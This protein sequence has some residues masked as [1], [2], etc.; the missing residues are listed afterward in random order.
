MTGIISLIAILFGT[1]LYFYI[2]PSKKFLSLF[3]HPGREVSRLLLPFFLRKLTG[4]IFFGFI[5]GIV[6][7]CFLHES[8]V[9]Y[10]LSFGRNGDF[11]YLFGIP[12]LVPFILCFSSKKPA[13][14]SRYPEMRIREWTKT[15][16]A[17]TVLSWCL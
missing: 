11:P 5:P 2:F 14:F 10:G 9:L 12:L 13:F 16:V 15:D 1:I 7:F 6:I 8:P 4:F 3:L 17:V